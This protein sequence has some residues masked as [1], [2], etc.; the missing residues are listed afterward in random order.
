MAVD[1]VIKI[2]QRHIWED[3]V[4]FGLNEWLT[5]IRNWTLISMKIGNEME[6]EM[7]FDYRGSHIGD[8]L[9]WRN[10]SLW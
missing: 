3:T 8:K 5:E 9:Q 7:I 2:Y 10:R 4:V 1:D 6:M